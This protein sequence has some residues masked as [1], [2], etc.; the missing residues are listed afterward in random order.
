MLGTFSLAMFIGKAY[1]N[2][3]FNYYAISGH[4]VS[5]MCLYI[6]YINHCL[7][8]FFFSPQIQYFRLNEFKEQCNSSLGKYQSPAITKIPN[9]AYWKQPYHSEKMDPS[10]LQCHNGVFVINMNTKG[11][12]KQYDTTPT[13]HSILQPLKSQFSV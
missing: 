3:S 5:K 7:T 6:N 10:L 11:L 2:H 9:L 13:A 4:L 12:A 8:T 1:Q